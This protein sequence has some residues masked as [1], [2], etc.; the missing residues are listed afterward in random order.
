MRLDY[1][2]AAPDGV[3]LLTAVSAYNAKNLDPKLRALV[4]LRVSQINGCAFCLNMHTQ[5]ARHAG[6]DQQRLDTLSAWRETTFFGEKERAA[7]AWAEAVTLLGPHGVAQEVFD[8]LKHHFSD[9]EIADLTLVIVT[10]NAWNRMSISFGA[11]PPRRHASPAAYDQFRAMKYGVRIHWG[12]YSMLPASRE[13]WSFLPLPDPDRQA[14]VDSYKKWDASGF[15]A[16]QWMS[17]FDRAG[18]K[19]FTITTKRLC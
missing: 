6:E 18:F 3:A 16:D 1:R 11:N 14:Y 2:K 8:A 19:C 12:L 13:S 15:D 9:K 17:F 10:M 4:E 7:L 5:E